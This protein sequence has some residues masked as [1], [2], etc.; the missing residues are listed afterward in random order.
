MSKGQ[1]VVIVKKKGKGHHGHHGGAWKVA[2]A[3]FVTAMMAFFLVMWLVGQSP[4]V[5][6]AVAGYFRD[7]GVFE[8]TRGGGVLPGGA[9]GLKDS[10]V[11]LP[12]AIPN[13]VKA[14]QAL[15]EE[16]AAH[17]REA[18][19]KVPSLK[20]LEDRIEITVTAEGLRI[21]LL[22]TAKSS[23]FAVGSADLLPETV[24][25][26]A[27]ISQELGTLGNAVALEGHTDNRAYAD[28]KGYGNWE[29]STDRA[30]AARRAMERFGLRSGQINAVRGYAN[31][32]LRTP[33]APLDARNRRI[34]IVVQNGTGK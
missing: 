21:E 6:A 7:P 26:L 14:A 30:N 10:G 32:R 19:A 22:E 34:S 12:K 31:T 16:A 23:F 24:Q 3:D 15:L 33:D 20:A 11:T 8:T 28:S 17:L 13:D 2:Y 25:I 4:N 5:K 27:V 18:L 1:P 29:L 9:E